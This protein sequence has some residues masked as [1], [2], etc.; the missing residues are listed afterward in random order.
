[1][2]N[3]VIS[4]IIILSIISFSA[5][6]QRTS[7]LT[8]EP[9]NT[10]E[11]MT[12]A[13]VRKFIPAIAPSMLSPEEQRAYMVEHYWDKFDFADTTFIAEVDTSHMATAFAIYAALPKWSV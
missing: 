3:I 12:P 9:N 8:S 10:S 6:R 2:K 4:V 13:K 11:A 1:M 5:C 7:V